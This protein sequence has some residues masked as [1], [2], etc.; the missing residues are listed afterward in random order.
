MP[1]FSWR[2]SWCLPFLWCIPSPPFVTERGCPDTLAQ[3]WFT[4]GKKQTQKLFCKLK[5]CFPWRGLNLFSHSILAV[6]GV[7]LF[8]CYGVLGVFKLSLLGASLE[9][10]MEAMIC[11]SAEFPKEMKLLPM[12][13]LS[14]SLLCL[15][16]REISNLPAHP[17]QI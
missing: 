14:V 5:V 1:F 12:A 3:N 13:C 15:R 4:L 11:F 10:S 7:F 16:V 8:F 17:S 2:P 9:L 6:L